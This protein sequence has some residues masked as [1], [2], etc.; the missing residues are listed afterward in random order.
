MV[1]SFFE[2]INNMIS[3]VLWSTISIISFKEIGSLLRGKNEGSIS[4]MDK[5]NLDIFFEEFFNN[6]KFVMAI[7]NIKYWVHFGPSM[8]WTMDYWFGPMLAQMVIPHEEANSI[9]IVA[10]FV[11]K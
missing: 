1:D 5:S 9:P 10:S 11:I 6:I 7:S 8:D 4:K 2:T 3:R